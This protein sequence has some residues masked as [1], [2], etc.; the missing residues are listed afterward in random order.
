[1]IYVGDTQNSYALAQTVRCAS[2][3][4]PTRSHVDKH[5]SRQTQTQAQHNTQATDRVAVC[6]IAVCV[7]HASH[8]PAPPPGLSKPQ[9]NC[10]PVSARADATSTVPL[11]A[12]TRSLT[13]QRN[14]GEFGA[15]K[16]RVEGGV[17]GEGYQSKTEPG[18][19]VLARGALV[20]LR[21]RRHALSPSTRPTRAVC[22]VEEKKGRA[23]QREDGRR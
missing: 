14:A 7:M 19:A 3:L 23:L 1:M 10:E 5:R 11:W 18:A 4:A 22:I 15:R 12:L 2:V 6:L 9:R 20:D 8:L 21:H 13:C 17:E 16:V